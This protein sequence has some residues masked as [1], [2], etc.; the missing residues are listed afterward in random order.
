MYEFLGND[1]IIQSHSSWNKSCLKGGAEFGEHG[2]ESFDYDL[3]D[4]FVHCIAQADW[5][6]RSQAISPLVFW[7]KD[8]KGLI[9]MW[10][11]G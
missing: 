7:N 3:S 5:S 8:Y 2:S 9:Q 1:H 11:H 6:E 10:G 4:H